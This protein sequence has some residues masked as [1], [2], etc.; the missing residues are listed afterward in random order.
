M[1][2][3]CTPMKNKDLRSNSQL[4]GSCE[5]KYGVRRPDMQKIKGL[6]E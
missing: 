4:I 6:L 3:N 1:I 2:K 5:L